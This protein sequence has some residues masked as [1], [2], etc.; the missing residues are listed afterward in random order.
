M[1]TIYA[2]GPFR[3]EEGILG[4]AGIYPGMLVKLNSEGEYVVHATEGGF[5]ERIFVKEDNFQGKTVD[6]VL[7]VDEPAQLLI[8]SKGSRCQ[9]LLEAGYAYVE[10]DQLISSGNGKLKPKD[11]VDSDVTVE[12]VVAVIPVDSDVDLSE[13]GSADTLKVVRIL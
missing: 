10:G 11:D 6:D 7:T 13:S 9:A 1:N 3:Q 12:D 4:A 8:M 2:E 5:A